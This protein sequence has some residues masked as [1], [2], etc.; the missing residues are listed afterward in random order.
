MHVYA[1]MNN[2]TSNNI[3]SM[4]LQFDVFAKVEYKCINIGKC[5]NV[6]ESYRVRLYRVTNK[7]FVV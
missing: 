7:T 3:K 1:R 6:K 2:N 4:Y 5:A